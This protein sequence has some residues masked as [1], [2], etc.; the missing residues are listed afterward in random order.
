[1]AG[2]LTVTLNPALDISTSTPVLR[3]EDKL[4]C[5]PTTLDTGGG[6]VNVARAIGELGGRAA[7]F[8]ALAGHTG[9]AFRDLLAQEPLDPVVFDIP[10]DTRQSFAVIDETTGEQYRFVMPGPRWSPDLAQ[11][12]IEGIGAA[13]PPGGYVVLSGSQ[14]PGVPVHF[15]TNLA[16]EVEAAD[17]K[18]ILDTSGPPLHA[19]MGV[20]SARQHVLR[21]DDAE[22]AELAGRPL[23]SR[24]TVADFASSLI[25]RDIAEIVVLALGP[26]GSVLATKDGAWHANTVDVQ[27]KSKVGAGDSFVGAFTLALAQGAAPE[28]ALVRGCAGASAAVMSDATGLCARADVEAL[29]KTATL[30]RL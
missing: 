27:V 15:P 26:D 3:P 25:S 23:T 18:L 28:E 12:A 19:L 6:G 8:V 20:G 14:P 21:L 30:D 1:M 24:E 16:A 5:R 4:R 9:A 22:S 11:E 7:A 13:T 2:I 17:A 10:G 29:V